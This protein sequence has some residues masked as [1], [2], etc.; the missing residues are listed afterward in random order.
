MSFMALFAM[1]TL[2]FLETRDFLS[3][4]RVTD[5]ALD[6]NREQK[7][8]VNFNI[9]MMDL[10]CDY[11]VIDV[12]SVL[13]TEQN[14]TQNVLKFALDQKGV[15]KLLMGKNKNQNDIALS[16]EGVKETIEELHENGE[17]AVS[18]DETTLKFALNEYEFVF[19][20]FFA[21]WCSHCRDLAP[22]WETLAE[23]M[24]DAAESIVD[25]TD[26]DYSDQEYEEAVK[27]ELPVFI[28]KVDCV[29]H[30]DLCMSQSIQAYPTLR[31]FHDGEHYSDYRGH[32]EVVE[33]THWLANLEEKIHPNKPEEEKKLSS[34]D[35]IARDRMGVETS[36]DEMNQVPERPKTRVPGSPEEK[37]WMEKMQKHRSRQRSVWKDDD[38]FGC[39]L[40]GFL[41]VDRAPGHFRIQ[42]QSISHDIAAHMT[43]VSHEVHE[44][45][46]GDPGIVR[47]IERA[48][49]NNK[50][51]YPVVPPG[52]LDATHPMNGNV[53]ITQNVHEAHHHYLKVITTQLDHPALQTNRW[54]A[55][56]QNRRVYTILQSSQLSFYK[57]DIVP[58][59]RFI[60]DLSPISVSHRIQNRR[61]YDY[62]TS[63]MAIV[64]GTFTV[65]GMLDGMLGKAVG[66]RRR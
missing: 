61:W 51:G 40:S 44:L 19:V 48:E 29:V 66:K 38:H 46:F 7:V 45:T 25:D 34:A 47:A 64:G 63:L 32:R 55:R 28:A 36:R 18:L 4:K 11:A 42:A 53:Y 26:H 27:L 20:D 35:D 39:Q 23:V 21:S 6:S 1:A 24:T 41:M 49:L 37:D 9:T 5:L 65:L 30:A 15:R 62:V 14:V 16:D 60:Y 10:K 57:S 8:R 50:E 13:G 3:P 43:N 31:L 58:D 17:D 52:T 33:I 59:A 54:M 22:T 12:V 2:G 56:P